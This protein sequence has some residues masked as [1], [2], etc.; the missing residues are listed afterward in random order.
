M[1][2]HPPRLLV[3]IHV[4][5]IPAEAHGLV[6]E[7]AVRDDAIA[8]LGD[9][10]VELVDGVAEHLDDGGADAVAGLAAVEVVD[11]EVDGAGCRAPDAGDF[12][13]DGGAGAEGFGEGA[14]VEDAMGRAMDGSVGGEMCGWERIGGEAERGL[15]SLLTYFPASV[16]PSLAQT[17]FRGIREDEMTGTTRHRVTVAIHD[18]VRDLMFESSNTAVGRG[19]KDGRRIGQQ[20]SRQDEKAEKAKP[21]KAAVSKTSIYKSPPSLHQ[22]HKT[23]TCETQSKG[24]DMRDANVFANMAALFAHEPGSSRPFRRRD[25][26]I[27]RF[28]I[29]IALR[30]VVPKNSTAPQSRPPGYT[31]TTVRNGMPYCLLIMS[32]REA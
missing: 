6:V 23:S 2:H 16:L 27:I 18:R 8:V 14:G 17:W 29:R 4:D 24:H 20:I 30:R 31:P 13:G 28:A 1:R 25:K 19:R 10:R 32:R 15:F 5:G 21:A 26:L 3:V 11:F 12:D 7:G 22:R 9:V